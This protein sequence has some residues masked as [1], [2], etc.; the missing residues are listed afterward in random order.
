MYCEPDDVRL[1]VGTTLTD[2]EIVDIIE[3]S[4]AYIDKMLGAQS[5]SDKLIKRLSMLLTAKAIKTSQ[6][7]S[8]A[9]SESQTIG[10]YK[11]TDEQREDA[12]DVLEVW[13]REIKEIMAMYRRSFKRV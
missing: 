6:P 10:E 7:K 4:D 12:G 11:I 5:L 1:M 2:D 3:T 13:E 9:I 8:Q